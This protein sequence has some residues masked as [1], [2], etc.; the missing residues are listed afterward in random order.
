MG[1][2]ELVGGWVRMKTNRKFRTMHKEDIIKT[3]K[4]NTCLPKI[5]EIV[6]LGLN[7]ASF[8]GWN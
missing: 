3:L 1:E 8:I 5:V 6:V 4:Y 7:I 2:K